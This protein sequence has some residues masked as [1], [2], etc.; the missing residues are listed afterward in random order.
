MRANRL[1]S[2]SAKIQKQMG[3]RW[4]VEAM[5]GGSLDKLD[6]GRLVKSYCGTLVWVDTERVNADFK[7]LKDRLAGNQTVLVGHN[8]FL[9]LVYF[10]RCFFGKLP[11]T[12]VDFQKQIHELF[13]LVIDTKYMAT[14]MKDALFARSS[15]ENLDEALSKRVQPFIGQ[16]KLDSHL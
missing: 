13:P 15:L 8:V 2:Y 1:E 14:Y 3:I 9:D 4:F 10:Y 12:V 16:C 6:A 11:D 7:G 5:V